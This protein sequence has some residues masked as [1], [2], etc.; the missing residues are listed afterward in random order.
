M[1]DILVNILRNIIIKY[2]IYGIY[3]EDEMSEEVMS[4]S[5]DD[6]GSS[7]TTDDECVPVRAMEELGCVLSK[8][9]IFFGGMFQRVCEQHQLCYACVSYLTKLNR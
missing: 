9:N 1:G 5:A 2:N 7:L 8:R 6:S 4:N 3:L